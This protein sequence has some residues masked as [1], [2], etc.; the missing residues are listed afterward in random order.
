MTLSSRLVRFSSLSVSV[1]AVSNTDLVCSSGMSTSGT[2]AELGFDNPENTAFLLE[3][4][5]G[6]VAL[7]ISMQ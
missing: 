3:D 2:G 7:G 5:S 4:G 1:R 6:A